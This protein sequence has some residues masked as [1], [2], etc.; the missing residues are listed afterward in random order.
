[1]AHG[2]ATNATACVAVIDYGMGNLRSVARAWQAVGAAVRVVDHP[3]AIGD[4]RA[5][6]FPGQGAIV[7]AMQALTAHGWDSVIR[8]WIAADRPFFGICLG[9]QALF[10]HSEEGDT[11]CL[12]VFRGEVRRFVPDAARRIKVPHMGWNRVVWQQRT[13][14]DAGLADPDFYFVHSYYALPADPALVWGATQHG[15]TA[16]CSAIAHGNCY[17][18]QFHPEKSQRAGLALYRQFYERVVCGQSAAATT[19]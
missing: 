19:R 11:P 9:L 2:L 5:L 12:G 3:Q 4:A 13:V 18:T 17:A 16:F 6:V 8:D 14:V 15:D 10:D 7:D 1:M